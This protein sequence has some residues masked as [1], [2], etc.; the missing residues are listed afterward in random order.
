MGSL[1]WSSRMYPLLAASH[2][3]EIQSKASLSLYCLCACQQALDFRNLLT[4]AFCLVETSLMQSEQRCPVPS[5][6]GPGLA[7]AYRPPPLSEKS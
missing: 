5:G 2:Q 7:S 1:Q 6:P 3:V 4:W